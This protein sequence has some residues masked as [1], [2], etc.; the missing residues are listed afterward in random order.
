MGGRQVQGG[1]RVAPAFGDARV[2]FQRG[3]DCPDELLEGCPDQE[4]GLHVVHPVSGGHHLPGLASDVGGRLYACS[5]GGVVVAMDYPLCHFEVRITAMSS[6][7][8]IGLE[9]DR[10]EFRFRS[11]GDSVDVSC[12][13]IVVPSSWLVVSRVSG[14]LLIKNARW[15]R[16]HFARIEGPDQTMQLSQLAG[17]YAH[18]TAAVEASSIDETGPRIGEVAVNTHPA[19]LHLTCESPLFRAELKIVP[20]AALALQ[21]HDVDAEQST[22]VLPPVTGGPSVVPLASAPGQLRDL[23]GAS[24]QALTVTPNA[25][26]DVSV[27]EPGQAP[28][29]AAPEGGTVLVQRRSLETRKAEAMAPATVTPQAFLD[30][31]DSAV[32]GYHP[33]SAPRSFGPPPVVEEVVDC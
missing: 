17:V 16:E 2:S 23:A 13:Q 31:V 32:S 26:T 10:L 33:T 24:I 9:A 21:A 12:S 11:A 1:G 22:A 29:A 20:K 28:M 30:Q 4:H 6:A 15:C 3:H 18:W 19:N 25:R 5:D 27:T 14:P 7:D 8:S